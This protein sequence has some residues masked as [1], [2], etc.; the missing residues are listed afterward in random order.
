MDS[1]TINRAIALP[2]EAD[3][4]TTS[5]FTLEVPYTPPFSFSSL[6]GFFRDRSLAGVELIDKQSYQR[7]VIFGDSNP[8][9]GWIRVEDCPDRSC[10]VV[11]AT[12]ILKPWE[13][14]I[15]QQV[16]HLFDTDCN[17]ASIACALS[18]LPNHVS[19]CVIEGVRVPGC[20]NGFETACR[21]IL[22]QQISVKA[23]NKLAARV[24]E[25]YGTPIDCPIEGLTHCFPSPQQIRAI[26][27]LESAFGV[28]GIIKTRSY[29]IGEIARLITEDVLNLSP[30]APK[31]ETLQTLLSIKGIGP[32][33]AGYIALRVLDHPDV[34]LEIDAGIAH[35]LP[36]LSPKERRALAAQWQPWRSY[37]VLAIW[38]SLSA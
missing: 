33:T 4:A 23:A 22:G 13:S 15:A 25:A 27:S 3:A 10:L 37:A 11:T 28:L 14:A 17:P 16:S 5:L 34:F 19:S 12:A 9:A 32:W 38:N 29:C 18:T 7:A 21:A 2:S 24:V 1:S 6:L 36:T 30:Q 31:E 20:F 8:V 35:G 26:P